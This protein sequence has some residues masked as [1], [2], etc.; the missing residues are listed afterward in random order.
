MSFFSDITN[1][2]IFTFR[3]F[4]FEYQ[5]FF[6]YQISW[7]FFSSIKCHVYYQVGGRRQTP[8]V[9]NESMEP[10]TSFKRT[11]KNN[12][13]TTLNSH[14]PSRPVENFLKAALIYIFET[15]LC[16]KIFRTHL[17]QFLEHKPHCQSEKPLKSV[18]SKSCQLVDVRA[19][20]RVGGNRSKER[21]RKS[22]LV[23]RSTYQIFE[24]IVT[25]RI[26]IF[27]T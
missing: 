9:C 26:E 16:Y 7:I 6:H 24:W 1:Y 20:D 23:L 22:E 12:Q 18:D 2:N 13:Q 21:D 5:R 10:H 27:I 8:V 17:S 14:Y 19:K 11:K 3:G 25:T 4:N 15:K